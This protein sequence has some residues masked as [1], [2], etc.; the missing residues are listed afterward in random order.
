MRPKEQPPQG[1]PPNLSNLPSEVVSNNSLSNSYLKRCQH[2]ITPSI[3]SL[4]LRVSFHAQRLI[5]PLY[6]SL[7]NSYWKASLMSLQVLLVFTITHSKLLRQQNYLQRLKPPES[8][9]KDQETRRAVQRPEVCAVHFHCLDYSF[10]TA[11]Y[12]EMLKG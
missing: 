6:A 10:L 11:V 1:S 3:P 7:L 8:T 4:Y 12:L 9:M 2:N 5:M